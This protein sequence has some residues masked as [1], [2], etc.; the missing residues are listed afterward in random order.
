MEN[1]NLSILGG[2]RTVIFFSASP[3]PSSAIIG[4]SPSIGIGNH[5]YR[6]SAQ[7]NRYSWT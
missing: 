2:R 5:Q 7:I 6:P 3:T 4:K 1:I